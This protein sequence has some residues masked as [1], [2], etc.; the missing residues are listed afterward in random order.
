MDCRIEKIGERERMDFSW[1]GNDESDPA[2]GRGR[3]EMEGKEMRGRIYIHFGDD[4]GF[5]ARKGK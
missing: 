4:S 5:T 3:V 2:C 1:E